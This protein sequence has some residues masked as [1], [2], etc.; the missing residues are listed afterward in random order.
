M[1]VS[2]STVLVLSCLLGIAIAS[3]SKEGTSHTS[4]GPKILQTDKFRP[5]NIQVE[6][7]G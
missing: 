5:G 3:W 6:E 4:I 1:R 2:I 7:R